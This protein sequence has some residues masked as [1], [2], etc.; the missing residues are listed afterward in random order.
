MKDYEIA[1]EIMSKVYAISEAKY[2]HKSE[3]TALTYI[4]TAKIHACLEDWENAINL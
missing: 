1:L 3:Q 2:G 4:E